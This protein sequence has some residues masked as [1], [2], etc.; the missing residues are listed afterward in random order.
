MV[1]S[2]IIINAE[3]TVETWLQTGLSASADYSFVE[4]YHAA[5]P[6]SGSVVR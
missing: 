1:A 4:D 6:R 3:M 2:S 5:L